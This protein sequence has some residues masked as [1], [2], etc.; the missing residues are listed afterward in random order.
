[1][2]PPYDGVA[3]SQALAAADPQLAETIARVGPPTLTIR[4]DETLPALLRSIVYQQ[5]STKA[6]ATIHG[7]VLAAFGDGETLDVAAV[8]DAP[9]DALRACGLSRAK[10]AAVRDLVARQRAETLPP[11]DALLAMPDAAVIASLTAVR[12]VGPWTAQM[13]LIFNLGRPDVWPV[14]DLGVQEGVRIVQG[15]DDR[16]TA[17]AMAVLGEPYAP[18]RS[19]A[20]WYCWRAVHIAR[21][22]EP[23]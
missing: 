17:K 13:V 11:R 12:G 6:A 4:P 15:L 2:S 3:A 14:A 22:D 8:A 19:V 20:A 7:R 21:G 16:P 1:M 18:W 10:V 5:L 9:D 23:G